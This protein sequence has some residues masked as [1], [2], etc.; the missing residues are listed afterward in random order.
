MSLGPSKGTHLKCAVTEGMD[1]RNMY[2]DASNIRLGALEGL[3]QVQ[4]HAYR[5]LRSWGYQP[6]LCCIVFLLLNVF[7]PVF[8]DT[9]W[10]QVLGHTCNATSSW[11]W[12]AI[13]FCA[14]Y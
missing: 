3:V 4:G 9:S 7:A 11:I 5:F 2:M 6:A 8:Q 1:C 14:E 10:T 12:E 13:E